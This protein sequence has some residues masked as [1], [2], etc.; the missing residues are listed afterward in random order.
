MTRTCVDP[1]A[2]KSSSLPT[3]AVSE[4][5]AGIPL[6]TESVSDLNLVTLRRFLGLRN[7]SHPVQEASEGEAGIPLDP[8]CTESSPI[9]QSTPKWL[10]R[11]VSLKRC[12][13]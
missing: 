5:K 9:D 1:R 7:R 2:K 13:L 11:A 3:Q 6:G 12:H 8:Q 10:P 4:A